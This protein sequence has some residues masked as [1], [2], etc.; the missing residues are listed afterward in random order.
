MKTQFD[1]A[2]EGEARKG[3]AV[4]DFTAAIVDLN[5]LVSLFVWDRVLA[6]N[7]NN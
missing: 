2:G 5:S 3:K 1:L 6:I 7:V 4:K